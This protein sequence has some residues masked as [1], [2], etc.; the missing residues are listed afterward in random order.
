MLVF[1]TL[2]IGQGE[3][4]AATSYN[5]TGAYTSSQAWHTGSTTRWTGGTSRSNII[6]SFFTTTGCSGSFLPGGASANLSMRVLFC[7]GSGGTS[8]GSTFTSVTAKYLA[9]SVKAGTCFK[10]QWRPNNSATDYE[11]FDG[12]IIWQTS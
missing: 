3:A 8:G 12:K 11:D 1:S 2:A 4:Q 9:T 7:S 5:C 10:V 6:W